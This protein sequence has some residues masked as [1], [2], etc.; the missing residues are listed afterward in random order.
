MTEEEAMEFIKVF[1]EKVHSG[2]CCLS[3][4]HSVC[5]NRLCHTY[6]WFQLGE[7][8]QKKLCLEKKKLQNN[9]V[10]KS[11]NQEHTHEAKGQINIVEPTNSFNLKKQKQKLTFYLPSNIEFLSSIRTVL[12][13]L[14]KKTFLGNLVSCIPRSLVLHLPKQ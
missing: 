4:S 3:F 11:E 13:L 12:Y 7:H 8:D 14:F 9:Q 10:L 5:T 1:L 2:L 6:S